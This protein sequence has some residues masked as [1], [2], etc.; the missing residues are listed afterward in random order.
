MIFSSK[1]RVQDYEKQMDQVY[2]CPICFEY[3]AITF[4]RLL[5]HIRYAHSRN[6]GFRLTC[7]I[8]ECGK[9]YNKV[10]SYERHIR[11]EHGGLRTT[12]D[13]ANYEAAPALPPIV[14]H[15]MPDDRMGQNRANADEPIPVTDDD[16]EFAEKIGKFILSVREQKKLSI[17]CVKFFME[18]MDA[19]LNLAHDKFSADIRQ[20]LT[21]AGIDVAAVEGL[22]PLLSNPHPFSL[23]LEKL[24]TEKKK[25]IQFFKHHFGLVEPVE[26]MLG[27]DNAG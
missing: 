14:D 11:R 5:A 2:N 20:K 23:P 4:S 26:Y 19:M 13:A 24:K 15:H 12:N 25:Q 18:E 17:T 8:D 27:R 6:P 7:G 9:T 21:Q 3:G 1:T 22:E 16:E 10:D